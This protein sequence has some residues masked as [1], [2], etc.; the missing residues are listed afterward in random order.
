MITSDSQTRAPAF[1]LIELL[2]V[3]S[4]ISLLI[5]ILLPALGKAREASQAVE[6]LTHQRQIGQGAFV[7]A[8]DYKDWNAMVPAADPTFDAKFGNFYQAVWAYN[9]NVANRADY[10]RRLM[11]VMNYTQTSD[12]G[13]LFDWASDMN[14]IFYC[15]SD[16]N[17]VNS[18]YYGSYAT[19]Y[20]T[21]ATAASNSERDHNWGRHL[22]RCGYPSETVLLTDAD[23]TNYN[24]GLLEHVQATVYA[25]PNDPPQAGRPARAR[26]RHAADSTAVL[27]YDGHAT[28]RDPLPWRAGINPWHTKNTRLWGTGLTI[29]SES[30]LK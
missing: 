13:P 4:I 29:Y 20:S 8:A 25:N 23:A 16:P 26:A 9:G 24:V 21:W 30:F 11:P 6:C 28:Q 14:A 7:Y 27:W 12:G 5:S 18:R 22:S 1:T 17:D 19:P 15:P 10:L 3:I 2:V